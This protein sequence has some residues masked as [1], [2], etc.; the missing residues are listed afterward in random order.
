MPD[1]V[2]EAPD[3]DVADAR[4]ALARAEGEL[5]L[6]KAQFAAL[7]EIVQTDTAGVV[8][9]SERQ[10]S[11]LHEQAGEI[12]ALNLALAQERAR[13]LRPKAERAGAPKPRKSA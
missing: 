2:P 3:Q 10:R 11:Q 5:R 12:R 4:A 1:A 7:L 9:R 8:E 13:R 6:L